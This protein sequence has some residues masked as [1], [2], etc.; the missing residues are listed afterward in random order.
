[1]KQRR[2][3]GIAVLLPAA[4]ALAALAA[5]ALLLLPTALRHDPATTVR[6]TATR[7]TL[8]GL[9]AVLARIPSARR[10]AAVEA[11]SVPFEG[12]LRLVGPVG[13]PPDA[14]AEVE[15]PWPSRVGP[16]GE[17][18]CARSGAASV[19]TYAVPWPGVADG[20]G[21]VLRSPADRRDARGGPW[22]IAL[23]GLLMVGAALLPA[24]LVSQQFAV[25][26]RRLEQ[27]V[28]GVAGQG[29]PDGAA[30]APPRRM[31][32]SDDELA[33]LAWTYESLH[34]RFVEEV[35][36]YR[37]ARSRVARADQDKIDF[38][39]VMS[40]EL[41]TPLNTILGF[42]DL[43][44]EGLEGP[45]NPGQREDLRIVRE[46]GDHL[47]GL[48]NDILDLS[49]LRAGQIKVEFADVDLVALGRMVLDEAEGQR[50]DKPVRL[51]GDYPGERFVVR[52]DPR[53][54]RRVLQNVVGN[55]LKFTRQGEV[56]LTVRDAG[57]WAVLEVRDTGPGIAPD[58]LSRIFE[59]YQQA[60]DARA[61]RE[62]TGLGL[63][64]ARRFAELHH[65]RIE[66]TSRVGHGS[67][68][69]VRIPVAGPSAE[70]R[71]D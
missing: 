47:L 46:S 25:D 63:S 20:S 31:A 44:L 58:A 42:S 70:V 35:S 28:A 40:H 18:V 21:L 5:T 54:L 24:M 52:G 62:G 48:V 38:L 36:R 65:G 59:E 61:K 55:A 53:L 2:R 9:A 3:F 57:D 32:D 30:P 12:T 51:A 27:G 45:I 68:F 14:A 29:P 1:M 19:C 26:L 7:E 23:F 13:D 6:T 49:A 71:G 16:G 56:R 69:T 60:G 66:A 10:A 4:A 15:P 39:A 11:L 22:F 17:V 34:D 50:R 43:L 64:I 67:V 8:A 37:R 33:W 41:R